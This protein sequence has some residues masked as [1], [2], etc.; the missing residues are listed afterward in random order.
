MCSLM[1]SRNYIILFVPFNF[2]ATCRYW[3]DAEVEKNDTEEGEL[4][5]DELLE[6]F[7]EDMDMW[8]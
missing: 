2:L 8:R 1:N 7:N 3:K 6:S 4:L 5:D